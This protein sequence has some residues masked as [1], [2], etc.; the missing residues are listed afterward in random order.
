[1]RWFKFQL[2]PV[3]HSTYM[4][5]VRRGWYDLKRSN[6]PAYHFS[7]SILSNST[8]Y[9]TSAKTFY[10]YLFIQPIQFQPSFSLESLYLFSM[11][12]TTTHSTPTDPSLSQPQPLEQSGSRRSTTQKRKGVTSTQTRRPTKRRA[13]QSV[14][15]SQR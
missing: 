15:R 6:V 3:R 14:R 2:I 1:M 13:L 12:S 11:A 4:W 8:L 7:A 9:T 5:A 10:I